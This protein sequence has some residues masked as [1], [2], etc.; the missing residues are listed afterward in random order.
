MYIA[1]YNDHAPGDPLLETLRPLAFKT[2]L[3]L[4]ALLAASAALAVPTELQ[5]TGAVTTP[6][7]YDL[8]ALEVRPASCPIT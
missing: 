4:A 8:S 6:K 2:P 5:V 7:T 3:A 1:K